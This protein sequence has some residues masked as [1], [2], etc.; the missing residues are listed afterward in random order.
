MG[1]T[2]RF[3]VLSF[4]CKRKF[5]P[6]TQSLFQLLIGVIPAG[7][8]FVRLFGLISFPIY[9]CFAVFVVAIFLCGFVFL[10]Y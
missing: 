1:W 9:H 6:V 4:L 7:W 10:V 3:E 5:L 8:S 2:R